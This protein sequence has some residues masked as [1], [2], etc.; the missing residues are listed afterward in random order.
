MRS[1]YS[2]Y[3]KGLEP[4]LLRTWHTSTRPAEV[5]IAPTLRWTGLEVRRVD[6]GGPHDD[7]GTVEFVARY[8]LDGASGELHE[9]S[10]FVRLDGEWVYLDGET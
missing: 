8:E 3:A 7:L 5:A 10:R 2:A 4:Y 9:V 6:A 1:R